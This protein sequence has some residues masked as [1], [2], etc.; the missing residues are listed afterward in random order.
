MV[1][2]KVK[3]EKKTSPRELLFTEA[4]GAESCLWQIPILQRGSQELKSYQGSP[5]KRQER[6]VLVGH[7]GGESVEVH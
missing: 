3:I 5:Q 6:Q 7:W 2:V 1:W 4:D